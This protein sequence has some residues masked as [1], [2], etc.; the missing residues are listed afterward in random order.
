MDD[1]GAEKSSSQ[2]DYIWTSND[3]DKD[4]D[5]GSADCNYFETS[6]SNPLALCSPLPIAIAVTDDAFTQHKKMRT[7]D[8]NIADT[9]AGDNAEKDIDSSRTSD[10]YVEDGE[11]IPYFKDV[12]SMDDNSVSLAEA[13]GMKSHHSSPEM[14]E[15]AATEATLPIS[16]DISK[17][18]IKI[19]VDQ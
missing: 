2:D 10:D 11:F 3:Y 19:T 14:V 4:D 7:S 17:R 1:D 16:C 15:M 13:T 8:V 12:D 18:V 6:A 5:D 9:G